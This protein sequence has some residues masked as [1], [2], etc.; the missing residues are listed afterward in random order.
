MIAPVKRSVLGSS[1]LTLSFR[2][3]NCPQNLGKS[4]FLANIM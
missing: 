3:G 2:A 4:I 1:P